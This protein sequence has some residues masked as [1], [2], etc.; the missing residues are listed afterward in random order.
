LVNSS[1]FMLGATVI[2]SLARNVRKTLEGKEGRALIIKRKDA[3][4]KKKS[5]Q[6]QQAHGHQNVSPHTSPEGARQHEKYFNFE[7]FLF[8]LVEKRKDLRTAFGS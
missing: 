8:L 2:V 1:S 5:Q 3:G 6:P 7:I 4:E